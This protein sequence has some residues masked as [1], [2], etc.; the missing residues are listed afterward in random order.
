MA[1]LSIVRRESKDKIE[2]AHC[3]KA[4]HDLISNN[5]ESCSLSQF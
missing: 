2:I 5:T 3:G 1:T 4:M